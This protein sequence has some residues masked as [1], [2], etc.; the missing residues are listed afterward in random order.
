MAHIPLYISPSGPNHAVMKKFHDLG[1]LSRYT[2]INLSP[3]ES[4]RIE[5]IQT[6][7]DTAV[8]I[9][10]GGSRHH[11]SY[12]F[13]RFS[14]AEVKIN[15]DYHSDAYG[16]PNPEIHCANHMTKT[17]NLGKKVVI[18]WNGSEDIFV[19]TYTRSVFLSRDNPFRCSYQDHVARVQAVAMELAMKTDMRADITVDC[20]MFHG[21]PSE[22]QWVFERSEK[23]PRKTADIIRAFGQRM[24]K[25]DIFGL[26]EAICG[27]ELGMVSTAPFENNPGQ[28]II[29]CEELREFYKSRFRFR[30]FNEP[31]D[32]REKDFVN[33]LIS[34]AVYVYGLILDAYADAKGY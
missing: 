11:E 7:E 33:K 27:F 32:E 24:G 2:W 26:W 31:S 21:F 16:L 28:P 30:M 9:G 12:Y 17:H 18:V 29:A 15:L 25:L 14:D 34:Y 22:H 1:K 6:R 3:A 5:S 13:T 10:G 4:A 20:D 19:S 23:D 8:F